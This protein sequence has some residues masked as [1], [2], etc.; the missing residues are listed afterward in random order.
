MKL[1][2]TGANKFSKSKD[3]KVLS[4]L[5]FPSILGYNLVF[6]FSNTLVCN[7]EVISSSY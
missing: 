1:T 5:T 3:V 4:I 6:I 7:R 2:S